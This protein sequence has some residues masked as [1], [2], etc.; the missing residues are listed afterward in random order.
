MLAALG[1]MAMPALIYSAL[2]HGHGGARGWGIPMATDIPFALGVLALL[3][4]RIPRSLKVFLMA[5]AIMDD[6]GSI[7]VI[8]IF[9]AQG[10][11]WPGL[12]YALGVFAALLAMGR[13]GI[14]HPA[15]YA[16]GGALLW[17]FLMHAGVHGTVAGVLAAFAIPSCS[18]LAG[19][20]LLD[21]LHPWTSY[22]ILPLFALANA[23]VC[24]APDLIH[25]LGDRVSLGIFL[26]LALGKPLGITA[27]CRAALA[28][29][30]PA[31]SG[32]VGMRH[33]LGVGMLGG[34]GFT[35]SIF[36]S[37]LAFAEGGLLDTAKVAVFLASLCSGLLGWIWLRL[38]PM[39]GRRPDADST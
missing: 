5:L 28:C 26:G 7:L 34:I 29:G 19:K 17:A 2:N 8:A 36:I 18:T 38:T 6:L 33:L 13:K 27:A 3:D 14:S 11:S 31:L 24:I 12:A 20:P 22:L 32:G 37:G 1:G 21:R 30:L 16:L 4:G 23:G 15:Y 25:G 39:E 10:V 9:Y 35:M